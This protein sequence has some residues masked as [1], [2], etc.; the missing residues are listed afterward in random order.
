[1]S[2]SLICSGRSDIVLNSA[3]RAEQPIPRVPMSSKS[4]FD[5][6]WRQTETA[7]TSLDFLDAVDKVCRVKSLELSS[8]PKQ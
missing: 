2:I 7:D 8:G 3:D 6:Y 1:M 4:H 5:I